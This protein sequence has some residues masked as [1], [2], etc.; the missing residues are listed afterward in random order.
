MTGVPESR[1]I[2]F[3]VVTLAVAAVALAQNAPLPSAVEQAARSYIT[4]ASL[5]APIRFLSSDLLE[6]RGPG[7][8][9]DALATAY[10][11]SQLEA[12]GLRPAG[13]RGFFQPFDIVGVDGHAATVRFSKG[14]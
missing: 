1:R 8:R 6:G 14:S 3:I 7:T 13:S 12:L 4:R 2:G 10:I 9:G 5:E 11:A